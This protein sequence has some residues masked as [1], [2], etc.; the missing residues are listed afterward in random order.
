MTKKMCECNGLLQFKLFLVKDIL[1]RYNENLVEI[2]FGFIY[3]SYWFW[4]G[5]NLNIENIEG[6]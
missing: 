1:K 3:N 6:E 5:K 4:R 2:F